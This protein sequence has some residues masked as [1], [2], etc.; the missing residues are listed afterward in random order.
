MKT[1]G[2]KSGNCSCNLK[3]VKTRKRSLTRIRDRP[4]EYFFQQSFLMPLNH[5]F[6]YIGPET[7][8]R[9]GRDCV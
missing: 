5:W 9:V 8:S 1:S 7:S 3:R 4:P 6:Q 2:N